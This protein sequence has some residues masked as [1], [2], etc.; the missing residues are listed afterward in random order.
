MKKRLEILDSYRAIAILFVMFFHYFSRY[1]EEF[2]PKQIYPYKDQYNYFPYGMYGVQLF[3]IISGFVIAY[4]LQGTN[5]IRI[6]WMKRLIRLLPSLIISSLIVLLFFNLFDNNS[7]F[8]ECG[9][10]KNLL[11]SITFINPQL[12]KNLGLELN[13]ICL[14]H[15]S[16]W[17]EIQFY[18]LVSLMYFANKAKFTRNFLVLSVLLVLIN[19]FFLNL[20]HSNSLHI[21]NNESIYKI[22][23]NWFF[24]GFNLITYL[25]YFALGVVFKSFYEQ[26][27]ISLSRNPLLSLSASFFIGYLYFQ[28][29]QDGT[30]LLIITFFL[31]LFVLFLL[32]IRVVNFLDFP[33]LNKIGQSSYF[34]YLIHENIGVFLIISIGL[35]K[36]GF[37]VPLLIMVLMI[38]FSILFFK[39]IEVPLSKK[40]LN[41]V[42]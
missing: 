30:L 9:N 26:G 39:K 14:C 41:L 34:L 10:A 36:L 23:K 28:N 12:F 19:H 31:S 27:K 18:L 20:G 7:I 13:Y 32:K 42:K 38:A 40:L 2:F 24:D 21:P 17:V 1:S 6:F 15:W 37:V 5:S 33:L 11:P 4:T 8:P 3:F 29:R 22:Y 25:P 35:V 16:L